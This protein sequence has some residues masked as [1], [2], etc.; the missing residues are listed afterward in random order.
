MNTYEYRGKSLDVSPIRQTW[1]DGVPCYEVDGFGD[2]ASY[3][4][5]D[6]TL[7]YSAERAERGWTIR[8]TN[9]IIAQLAEA[10]IAHHAW[11]DNTT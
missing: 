11:G 7:L 2:Q 5:S 8:Y 1:H 4:D 9:S 3:L 6:S 10:L